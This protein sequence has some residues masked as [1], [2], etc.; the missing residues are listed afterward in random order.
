MYT[1]NEKIALDQFAEKFFG[2]KPKPYQRDMIKL[3]ESGKTKRLKLVPPRPTAS[4]KRK[5]L[6]EFIADET[7]QAEIKK[8]ASDMV[9]MST[10]VAFRPN[11]I[12]I[13]DI[14]APF[15]YPVDIPLVQHEKAIAMV[16]AT[17]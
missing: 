11:L 5:H 16:K 17:L 13:D 7:I 3:I 8:F 4:L 6:I 1:D 12:I 14:E 2:I 15:R 9:M 10:Q